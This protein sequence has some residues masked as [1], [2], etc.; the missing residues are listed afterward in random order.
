VPVKFQVLT[1]FTGGVGVLGDEEL[2]QPAKEHPRT[3]ARSARIVF[4]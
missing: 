4:S 2:P 3:S 1:K